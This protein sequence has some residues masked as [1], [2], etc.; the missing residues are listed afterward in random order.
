M[1]EKTVFFID[2]AD[3]SRPSAANF[4]KLAIAR[5]LCEQGVD[6]IWSLLASSITP[7][8]ADDLYY[9]Q[10][11]FI[12]IGQCRGLLSK[13]KHLLYLYRTLLLLGMGSK[14]K[15]LKDDGNTVACFT[16]GYNFLHLLI[17][18]RLCKRNG[19]SLLHERTEYPLLE[20]KSWFQKINLSLY[21]NHFIP[22]CGHI[23]VISTSL[24]LF[25]E[26]LLKSLNVNVPVSIMNML[27]EPD[28]Y[29]MSDFHNSFQTR[30][31]VYIG[32]LYGDKD[33]VYNLVEAFSL[34]M[35]K[36]PDT[37]LVIVGDTSKPE[38]M[39]RVREAIDKLTDPERVLL[40]GRLSRQGVIRQLDSAYCLA[41]ARPDNIQAK[42]GF[43]TKLGEYLATGKPVVITAVGDIPLFLKDGVNAY[44]ADPDNVISFS[45]KLSDCLGNPE[46]AKGTGLKGME[47]VEKDFNYK[48]V[49]ET[50]IEAINNIDIPS[51]LR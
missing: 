14:L 41:L 19:I 46:I 12:S 27:V 26:K 10:I 24:K 37:R 50:L 3:L 25:F 13:N 6:V 15:A 7:E 39:S 16:S 22:Q 35:D 43:P 42:Y 36:H 30:D 23:F 4:R 44:L 9:K 51:R 20:S 48:V 45:E 28:R 2:S 1:K 11:R 29:L 21:L 34:L 8:I 47:L 33:G 17:L 32:T 38:K 49:V 31:I 40:T 18:A 5:A